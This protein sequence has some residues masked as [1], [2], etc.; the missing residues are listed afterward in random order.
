MKKGMAWVLYFGIRV[1]VGEEGDGRIFALDRVS[2]VR[3]AAFFPMGDFL[4][5]GPAKV[6]ISRHIEPFILAGEREREKK[7]YNAAG[8]MYPWT[9][10]LYSYT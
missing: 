7:R 5:P 9:Y 1:G 2:L 3:L 4:A 10:V 6:Y 8:S